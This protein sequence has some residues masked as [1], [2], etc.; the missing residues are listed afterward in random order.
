LKEFEDKVMVN[1][2][3]NDPLPAIKN[4]ADSSHFL[5]MKSYISELKDKLGKVALAKKEVD[6]KYK[7]T[8]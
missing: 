2:M 6:K 8:K 5:L 1:I 4:S 7:S 3:Q